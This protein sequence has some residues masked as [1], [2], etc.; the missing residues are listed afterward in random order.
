MAAIMNR[1]GIRPFVT[2]ALGGMSLAIP[3][4]MVLE[5]LRPPE[6]V[7]VPLGPPSLEGL[8]RQRGVVLPVVSL[9]RILGLPDRTGADGMG[10]DAAGTGARADMAARLVVVSHRGQPVGLLVDR[11]TGLFSVEEGRITAAAGAAQDE[12]AGEGGVEE[13]LLAGVIRATP[14]QGGALILDVDPVIERQFA[15][16]GRLGGPGVSSL[17]EAPRPAP[18]AVAAADEERLVVFDVS[19]QEYALPVAADEE[20]LVV[21]DVSGQEYALPVAAVQEIVAVPQAVT[22][23]P[24][25]GAHLLGV[26]TLRD[27]LV[28]LVDLRRLFRLA[29]GAEPV[30][31]ARVVVVRTPEGLVGVLVDDVREILRTPRGRID[32]VPPLLARETDF[33]DIAGI[34]RADGGR[35]IS[36]LSADRLFLRGA[37]LGTGSPGTGAPGMGAQGE[38]MDRSAV[39]SGA[40]TQ[41]FVVFRLAG[42]EYGLPVAAVQEVLRRPDAA[43]PLPNAPDFVRGVVTLRGGVLPLIDQRRLLRLPEAAEGAQARVVVIGTGAA[44][45]GLLVDGMAGIVHV[46]EDRI[47]AAPVVSQAQHRLIRRVAALDDAQSQ[48][49]PHN[50]PHSGPQDGR[51]MILLMDPAELLDLDQLTTLLAT[52]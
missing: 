41:A 13:A 11:M 48:D 31:G 16:L 23:V 24:R 7:K 49:G 34:L 52:V 1:E 3:L 19:G 38:A 14:E 22:R 21:F 30:H 42:A 15:D 36:I 33:E 39:E 32:P 27:A 28:P 12:G 26:T 50:G 51:R 37:A 9:R 5:I 10:A 44:R 29:D 4:D 43:T 45:A 46:P 35:L 17:G 2:F 8:A 47:G 25:V 20:R 18:A 40:R 6:V